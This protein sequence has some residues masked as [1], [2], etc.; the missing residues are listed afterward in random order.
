MLFREDAYLNYVF[1]SRSSTYRSYQY[2]V[3]LKVVQ[4]MIVVSLDRYGCPIDIIDSLVSPHLTSRSVERLG[5][6]HVRI[7][8]SLVILRQV[9]TGVDRTTTT[10]DSRP[11]MVSQCIHWVIE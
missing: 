9:Q 11:Q 3:A 2:R 1:P 4:Q 5:R 8:L 7:A 6:S 10:K